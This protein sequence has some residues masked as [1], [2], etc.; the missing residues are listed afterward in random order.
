MLRSWNSLS[1]PVV[2]ILDIHCIPVDS[3]VLYYI[4]SIVLG[5]SGTLIVQGSQSTGKYWKE[6]MTD[7]KICKVQV[8]RRQWQLKEMYPRSQ[9]WLQSFQIFMNDL[10]D[11]R[12][13]CNLSRFANITEL[14]CPC[15]H[16]KGPRQAAEVG[17]QKPHEVHER[18]VLG[19]TQQLCRKAPGGPGEDQAEHEPSMCPGAQ[20]V[21]SVGLLP[22]GWRRWSF[23]FA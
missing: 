3:E 6:E 17:S 9:S 23:L 19:V 8:K 5:N 20:A 13:E 22:E 10:D 16:L 21:S 14:V 4:P 18:E 11:D 1:S 12:A 2:L 7:K 15:C